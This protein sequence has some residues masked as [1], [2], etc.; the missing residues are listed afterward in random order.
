MEKVK[1]LSV[2][3]LGRNRAETRRY[4]SGTKVLQNRSRHRTRIET[5]HTFIGMND[6]TRRHTTPPPPLFHVFLKG[7]L[8]DI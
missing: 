2:V 3:V 7:N 5:I 6:Q 4:W 1:A 8:H